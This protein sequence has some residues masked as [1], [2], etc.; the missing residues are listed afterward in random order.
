M[1][2]RIETLNTE[3]DNYEVLLQDLQSQ[4]IRNY[5]YLIAGAVGTIVVFYGWLSEE[6]ISMWTVTGGVLV[7]VIGNF[8][9]WVW[10]RVKK[11]KVLKR[12]A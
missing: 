5:F 2:D 7:P 6:E 10:S 11:I 9:S 4:K 1:P 12:T 3:T 8:V